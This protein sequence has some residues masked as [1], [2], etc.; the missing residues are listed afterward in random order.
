[1]DICFKSGKHR[2]EKKRK[3]ESQLRSLKRICSNYSGKVYYCFFCG[4]YHVGRKK[5]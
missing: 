3:A 2:H 5:K 1:M 4:G